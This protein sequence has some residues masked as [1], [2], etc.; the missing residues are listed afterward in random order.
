ML[1]SVLPSCPSAGANEDVKRKGTS[2]H[3]VSPSSTAKQLSK[4]FIRQPPWE[5]S[6]SASWLPLVDGP[7]WKS[8][9]ANSGVDAAGVPPARLFKATCPTK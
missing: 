2:R 6:L 3:S 1:L 4:Q 9:E 7:V 8:G 5:R